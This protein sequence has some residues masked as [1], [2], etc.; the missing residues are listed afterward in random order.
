MLSQG[1]LTWCFASK[2]FPTPDWNPPDLTVGLQAATVP[3][4][5]IPA[6]A[7]TKGLAGGA[8][9]GIAIGAGAG[10]ALVLGTLPP[11]LSRTF[12]RPQNF[13]DCMVL[14]SSTALAFVCLI[15]CARSEWDSS[16]GLETLACCA[17]NPL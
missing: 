9:A 14:L 5:P 7:S 11:K 10:L 12:S 6:P 8:I 4:V 16:I 3:P 2:T 13:F 17:T 15:R 1:L